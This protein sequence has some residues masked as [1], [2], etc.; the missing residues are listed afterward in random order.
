[1]A[2]NFKKD[3]DTNK[4]KIEHRGDGVSFIGVPD[5][6]DGKEHYY[7]IGP[8]TPTSACWLFDAILLKQKEAKKYGE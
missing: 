2:N 4:W 1:M 6:Y 5:H 3:F 7:W 8:M